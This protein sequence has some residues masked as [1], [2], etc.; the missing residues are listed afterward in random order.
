[1]NTDAWARLSDSTVIKSDVSISSILARACLNISAAEVLSEFIFVSFYSC[2]GLR[3]A[4]SSISTRL[5]SA[6]QNGAQSCVYCNH[7]NS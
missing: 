5:L 4:Q 3:P 6:P 1:M 7:P 2:L